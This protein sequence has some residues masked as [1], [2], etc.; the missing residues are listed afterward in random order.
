ML[1]GT[2]YWDPWERS[3]I[4]CVLSGMFLVLGSINLVLGTREHYRDAWQLYF[5]AKQC[6]MN[7]LHLIGVKKN[8]AR[9]GFIYKK[10]KE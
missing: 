3:A 10:I 6:F 1:I 8:C 5:G 7:A 4:F 2:L 9:M